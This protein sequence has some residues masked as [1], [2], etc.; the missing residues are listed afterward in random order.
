M[1]RKEEDDIRVLLEH[2]FLLADQ[3][4]VLTHQNASLMQVIRWQDLRRQHDIRPG[5][6]MVPG[7]KSRA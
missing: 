6:F 2:N 4:R 7:L 1:S 5:A 3:V